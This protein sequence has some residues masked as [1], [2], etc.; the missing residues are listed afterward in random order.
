MTEQAGTEGQGSR[1]VGAEAK[2]TSTT[3]RIPRVAG[4]GTT[5]RV[6][7][8]PTGETG[9][10]PR[11]PTGNTGRL[12]RVPSTTPLAP[13]PGVT[14]API[15]SAAPVSAPTIS[16]LA[17]QPGPTSNVAAV[18]ANAPG[19]APQAA[20]V[21]APR[22]EFQPMTPGSVPSAAVP[23][24]APVPTAAK[25]RPGMRTGFDAQPGG[26]AQ[27][28][29]VAAGVAAKPGAAKPSGTGKPAAGGKPG[30]K[31][32]GRQTSKRAH[33]RITKVD[34]LSTLKM[35]FLLAFCVGIAVFVSL[36]MLWGVLVAT[37]VITSIQDL[38]NSVIGNPNSTAPIKLAEFLNT[39]RVLGFI[40]GISVINVFI[41]T[42]LG[43]ILGALYNLASVMFGGLEVTLEV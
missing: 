35:S 11:V 19:V 31:G 12:P 1:P 3:G 42:L 33:L 43:T 38:L 36:Y 26:T 25:G 18:L 23:G 14:P 6:P 40:A 32:R 7:R 29:A 21:A 13:T 5:G 8:V 39:T 37:G 30:A 17:A 15:P 20:P 28:G 4:T 41:I 9:R 2:T 10:I 22:P 16:P 27:A 34:L 24:G